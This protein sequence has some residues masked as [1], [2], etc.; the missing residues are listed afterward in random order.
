MR[1]VDVIAKK[2]DGGTLSREEIDFFVN[3]VSR[4]TLPDYQASALLMAIVL[5]GM[6]IDE[7]SWL[8]DSMVNSGNRVDLSDIPGVKVGKHS[9][10]GVGDKVSIVLAPLAAACGVI[11]PK[12]SGRGLGHTGGTLDKLESI[13]GC[14]VDLGIDEFKAVLRDVGTSIIGQTASLAPADKKLYALRD[15]TATIGSIP[16]ISASVMSKK[17]AEGSDVVI[18]DV[19]C[20]DGAFMKREADAAELAASMVAIGSR[21]GVRTEALITDMDAPLGCAVGNSVEVKECIDTLKGHG[22]EDLTGVV[23]RF[24]AR[25]LMLA[26]REANEADAVCRVETALS[27]GKAL[28][29]FGRMIERQGGN[30]AVVD[31][32]SLLPSVK[33]REQCL[34]PRDGYITRMGAEAIGLA[35]NLLG[36]GR[37]KVGEP[38][39]HAVG[40]VM[41]ARPGARVER[42]QPLIEIHHRDGRGVNAALALC[43]DAIVI[44]DEAPPARPVILRDVR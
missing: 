20:G 27:S 13:P 33:G 34:A 38:I 26:G 2:R 25:V 41:L 42:G 4:G 14:R 7:T 6:T 44:G 35:T 31:D 3:G 36:A 8:T 15:V 12:M 10:G 19:K 18:L 17:L 1:V 28:E 43:S 30:R 40:V 37:T 5:R 16:L 21:A 11:M 23:K 24:A 29:T 39:D 9:T 22:P 32:S